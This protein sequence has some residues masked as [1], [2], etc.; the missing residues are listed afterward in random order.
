M[1]MSLN[2]SPRKKRG[3]GCKRNTYRITGN[4]G[5]PHRKKGVKETERD[6]GGLWLAT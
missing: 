2:L 3:G 6:N 1:K 5:W 4:Y